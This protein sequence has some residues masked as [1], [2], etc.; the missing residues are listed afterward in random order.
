MSEQ[1]NIVV[2]RTTS[3]IEESVLPSGVSLGNGAMALLT[4]GL[5]SGNNG[6]HLIAFWNRTES[7]RLNESID[8]QS[9]SSKETIFVY[10]P[11]TIECVRNL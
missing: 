1:G 9:T 7:I 5:V 4:R 2:T 10:K 8:S 11:V 6:A 3:G